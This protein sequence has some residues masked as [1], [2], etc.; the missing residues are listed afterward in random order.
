[1]LIRRSPTFIDRMFEDWNRALSDV[2]NLNTLALDVHENEDN[3][4]IST[5]L[6]GVKEEDIEIRLH[7]DVLT[8]SAETSSESKEEENGKVLLQERR[9]GK[10]SRSVRFPVHVE[11]ENIVADYTNGVLNITIPKAEEVKPRRIAINGHTN[12]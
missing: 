12:S 9:Y 3:Y 7:D 11:A 2:T 8:V 5:D 1:M 4:L 10:F 6:P